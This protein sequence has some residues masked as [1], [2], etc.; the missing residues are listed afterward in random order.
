MVSYTLEHIPALPSSFS[1]DILVADVFHDPNLIS[2]DI[3]TRSSRLAY[4][5]LAQT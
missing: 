4:I 1:I 3:L 5:V 2:R